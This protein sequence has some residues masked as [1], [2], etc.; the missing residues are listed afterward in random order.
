MQTDPDEQLRSMFHTQRERQTRAAPHWSARFLRADQSLVAPRRHA[1][2]WLARAAGA[3][4]VIAF[5]AIYRGPVPQGHFRLSQQLPAL[6]EGPA[7]PL[8]VL[9]KQP[10]AETQP[11]LSPLAFQSP[12]DAFLPSRSFLEFP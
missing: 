8:F 3:G 6:F 10:G 4:L 5:L 2:V 11:G 12:S 7:Q 1:R 9:K